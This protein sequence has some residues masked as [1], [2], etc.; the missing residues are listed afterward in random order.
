MQ[1]KSVSENSRDFESTFVSSLVP[2]PLAPK[3]NTSKTLEGGPGAGGGGASGGGDGSGAF[4][5]GGGGGGALC[6]VRWWLRP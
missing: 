2:S 4:G 6:L 3:S 1:V 5:D